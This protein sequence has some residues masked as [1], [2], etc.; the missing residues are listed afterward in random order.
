MRQFSRRDFLALTSSGLVLPRRLLASPTPA[1][2]EQ[3]FLFIYVRGG[4]DTTMVFTPCFDYPLVDMEEDAE[5][6]EVSGVPFV[7]HADRPAVQN[8]FERF[9]RRACLINGMEV[10]SITHERCRRILMTGGSDGIADDWAVTLASQGDL[11]YPVPHLVLS[12]P[13]FAADHLSSVVRVGSSG[14][15]SALLDG[16]AVDASDISVGLPSDSAQALAESYLDRRLQSRLETAPA[17]RP[18]RV[19]SLYRDTLEDLGVLQDMIDSVNFAAEPAGCRRDLYSDASVAF[20]AFEQ[21]LS[22]CAITQDDGWCSTG[23]DTHAGN[24]TQSQ[25]YNE[26]FEY[27]TQTMDDLDGRTSYS[28]G[29][30]ADEVTIVVLSEMGRHPTNISDGRAHWTFT[31]A[32]LIGNQVR[33]GQVIGA[34]DSNFAGMP[35]DLGTGE[36]YAGGTSLLPGHLGA[37]LLKLGGHDPAEFVPTAAPIDA[38]IL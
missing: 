2:S 28:G 1:P 22:R 7:H 37:T 17:G 24:H 25:S 14:Q 11:E 31:S 5:L 23:W 18:Q 15:L 10:R 4:W 32:M 20:N 38:A 6:A 19:T 13:A 3:K 27:L 21:G 33:G 36:L 29:R 12:G 16:S 9:G 26:L 34:V 35:I 30:L 8:F